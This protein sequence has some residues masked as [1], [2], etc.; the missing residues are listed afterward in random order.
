MRDPVVCL[1]DGQTFER[2]AIAAWL[3]TNDASPISG[4]RLPSKELVPNHALRQMIQAA[5]GRS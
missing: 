4:E 1:G 3:E 2:A 5:C